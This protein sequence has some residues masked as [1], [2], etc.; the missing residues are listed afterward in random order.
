[1]KTTVGL[2]DA[3]KTVY[4]Q[5]FT[6]QQLNAGWN[7]LN[8][9]VPIGLDADEEYAFVVESA[10]YDD[11]IST[12][13]IGQW[14]QENRR[15]ITTQA[16]D[17]VLL[18]SA[19]RSTWT[20]VQEE[21]LSLK[22]Y[23]ARFQNQAVIELGTVN[24]ENITDLA[25]L[26]DILAPNGSNIR[27]SATLVERNETITISPYIPI[28]ISEYSGAILLK[29]E[30]ST[31]NPDISPVIAG[32]IQL[33]VGA[34]SAVSTYVSRYFTTRGTTLTVYLNCKEGS[35]SR[36]N[37]F[38]NDGA[39]WTALTRDLSQ[40]KEV[41][42]GFVEIPF[43]AALNLSQTQLKVELVSTDANLLDRPEA[44]NLRAIVS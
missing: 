31:A 22:M 35:K 38:Y 11:T 32:N 27:F 37:V 4:T 9:N 1:M 43:T 24:V 25:L 39:S 14:D 33:A 17:G 8:F 16:L 20:P 7:K 28:K 12:A 15:W 10:S 3:S 40:A 36:I 5:R 26:C 41:G 6:S 42:N 44:Q 13:R 18:L 29:A 23:K 21:D 34:V 2:P 19:N 30:L